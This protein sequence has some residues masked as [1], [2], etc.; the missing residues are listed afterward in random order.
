MGCNGS[1][2]KGSEPKKHK[3]SGRK[4]VNKK[5]E[6]GVKAKYFVSMEDGRFKDDYEVGT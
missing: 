2:S 1:N 3:S 6:V 4:H 5:G